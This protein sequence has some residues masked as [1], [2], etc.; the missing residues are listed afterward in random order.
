MLESIS[1]GRKPFCSSMS[2]FG[3]AFLT[4]VPA[5]VPRLNMGRVG[6]GRD[7]MKFDFLQMTPIVE[8]QL[9]MWGGNLTKCQSFSPLPGPEWPKSVCCINFGTQLSTSHKRFFFTLPL[10]HGMGTIGRSLWPW[11]FAPASILHSV[12]SQSA[13]NHSSQGAVYIKSPW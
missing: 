3:L 12:F 4:L 13:E 6:V 9:E 5:S 7:F 2:I 10:I 8:R 11:T 1:R